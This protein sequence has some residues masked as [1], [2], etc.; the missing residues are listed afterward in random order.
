MNDDILDR[1]A[2]R[3]GYSEHE[4]ELFKEK[5]HRIHD[6]NTRHLSNVLRKEE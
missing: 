2:K 1:Y 4:T 5:G 3:V 6:L